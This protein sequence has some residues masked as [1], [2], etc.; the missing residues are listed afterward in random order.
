MVSARQLKV[1]VEALAGALARHVEE[2]LAF[3]M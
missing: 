3:V 1:S 2:A